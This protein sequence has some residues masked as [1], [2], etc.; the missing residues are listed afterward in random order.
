MTPTIPRTTGNKNV[1]WEHRFSYTATAAAVAFLVYLL[2]YMIGFVPS[3]FRYEPNR[4]VVNHSAAGTSATV[5]DLDSAVPT[6]EQARR[7]RISAIGIDAKIMNPVSTD[8]DVLNNYLS[9][10]AVRWPTSGQPGHGN[11]FLFGHSSSL[12][13]VLNQAYKTFNGLGELEN[14]D[15]I[16]IE[17]IS[18]TYRYSV[19]DV[20]FRKNSAVYV[21]FDTGEDMLTLSTC[22][23]FGAKEDRIVVRADF[24]SYMPRS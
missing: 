5:A 11:L 1:Y 14:G 13:N 7:I 15:I 17:T 12:E 18:G 10:G 24:E 22:N 8:L 6:N 4:P 19:K 2:L 21:P 20:E 9:E 16:A 23:N 3:Q